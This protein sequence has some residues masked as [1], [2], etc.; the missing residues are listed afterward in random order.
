VVVK[1]SKIFHSKTIQNLPKL[2]KQWFE[3]KPSGNPGFH[4]TRKFFRA[5]K[6]DSRLLTKPKVTGFTVLSFER[7]TGLPD[8]LFSN[9]KSQFGKKISGPQI[10]K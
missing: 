5:K 9:Q 10:G 4:T 2:R 6:R 3:S 7:G 1:Y 8:G